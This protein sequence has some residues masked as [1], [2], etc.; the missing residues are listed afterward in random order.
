[1]LYATPIFSGRIEKADGSSDGVAVIVDGSA[2]WCNNTCYPLGEADD[3]KMVDG[4]VYLIKHGIVE[5]V[6]PFNGFARSSFEMPCKSAVPLSADKMICNSYDGTYLVHMINNSSVKL[7]A[8]ID[9]DRKCKAISCGQ[10]YI[11]NCD[12]SVY[13]IS[14]SS[15]KRVNNAI[16]GICI[17]DHPYIVYSNRVVD[18]NMYTVFRPQFEVANAKN[19]DSSTVAM[20]NR[21]RV[22]IISFKGSKNVYMP[23]VR[24]VVDI[25]KV[26]PTCC[27]VFVYAM[28][29]RTVLDALYDIGAHQK[30]TITC[31]GPNC[32]FTDGVYAV[33]RLMLANIYRKEE[34]KI[35]LF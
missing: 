17:D 5:V 33:K 16:A 13:I 1:M 18:M 3:V 30:I 20:W 32:V 11:L 2:Y 14:D 31:G 21:D 23:R 9:L 28:S 6:Y 12:G 24:E 4:A 22:A 7:S 8:K 29:D 27:D 19:L 15:V 26:S 35:K 34:E 10:N 25:F